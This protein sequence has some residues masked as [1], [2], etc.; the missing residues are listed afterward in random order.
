MTHATPS[1]GAGPLVEGGPGQRSHAC[2]PLP[3]ERPRASTRILGPGL[4]RGA[5]IAIGVEPNGEEFR[6]A[7]V[8]GTGE[9]IAGFGPFPEE[10]VVAHWRSLA[11][12]TGLPLLVERPDG[13]HNAPF[14]QIGPLIVGS[15]RIRRRHGLL[16]GRRPRFLVR[17]KTGAWPLRPAV[18]RDLEIIGQRR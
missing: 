10:E 18:H 5:G 14:P 4:H 17:R 6:L 11:R 16:N 3:G 9:V 2:S 1:T 13:G 15:I 12:F 8:S 7:I